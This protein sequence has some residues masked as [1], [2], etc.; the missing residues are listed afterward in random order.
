L[1]LTIRWRH[2]P[3]SK[4]RGVEPRTVV[5]DVGVVPHGVDFVLEVVKMPQV[6]TV[7]VAQMHLGH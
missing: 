3:I 5:H 6:A 1:T 2:E 7:A 4:R